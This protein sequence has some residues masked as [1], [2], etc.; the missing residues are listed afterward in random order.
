M[1][2]VDA[3]TEDIAGIIS[4]G[5]AHG[6]AG[7]VCIHRVNST[8]ALA[9]TSQDIIV[10]STGFVM[11]HRTDTKPV[12]CGILLLPG[13]ADAEDFNAECVVTY[14]MSPKNTITFSSIG[15]DACVVALQRELLTIGGDMLERQEFKVKSDLRPDTLLA[16]TGALLIL[17]QK[18]SE[19]NH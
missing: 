17:G 4:S 7:H 18:P 9:G 12:G 15:E 5:Y 19:L 11:V 3:G 13:D 1:T 10:I 14:G 6:G 8:A 2:V 16:V